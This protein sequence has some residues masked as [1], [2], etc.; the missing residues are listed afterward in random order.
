MVTSSRIAARL[1]DDRVGVDRVLVEH[2]GG[3]AHDDAR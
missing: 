3:V 1:L 2:L